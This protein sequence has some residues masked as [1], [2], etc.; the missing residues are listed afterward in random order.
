MIPVRSVMRPAPEMLGTERTAADA[1]ELMER[2]EVGVVPVHDE[3]GFLVGLVTD[4][5]LVLRVLARRRDPQEITLGEV[6]TAEVVTVP[7][8]VDVSE[9]RDLMAEHQI[10]RIPVVEEG[11]LVGILALGDIALVDVSRDIERQHVI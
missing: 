7:P 8:D 3:R 10:R 4:R 6:A 1:A 11:R 2:D 9:A 5:D